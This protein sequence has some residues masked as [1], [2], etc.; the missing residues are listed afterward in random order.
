MHVLLFALQLLAL[1]QVYQSRGYRHGDPVILDDGLLD[2]TSR[3]FFL[4]PTCCR[5]LIDLAARLTKTVKLSDT[6][7]GTSVALLEPYGIER[8]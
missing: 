1:E 6:F 3:V 2:E 8:I 7:A 4:D 5:S